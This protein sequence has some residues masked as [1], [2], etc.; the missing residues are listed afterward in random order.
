MYSA[1]R[2][3]LVVLLAFAGL[4]FGFG[5]GSG[6]EAATLRWKFKPG[7][8][9]RYTIDQKITTTAKL[10]GGQE[11]KN[12]L[13]QTVEMSWSVKS[14]NED[15]SAELTQTFDRVLD[16]VDGPFAKYE[17]D[18]KSGKEPEGPI[19]AARLPLFKAML[20]TPITFKMNA[21][22]EPSGFQVPEK[23]T[24]TLREAGPSA[25]AAGALFSEEGLKSMILQT[26]V[27]L[28]KDDL[29]PGKSWTRQTKESVPAIGT[30][31]LD[32][33]FTYDGP[34]D[35][36]GRKL[37]KIG[38]TTK[39]D[40]KPPADAKAEA[41]FPLKIKSQDSKGVIHFDN[42]AGHLVHLQLND[43]IERVATIMN[44]EINEVTETSTTRKLVKDEAK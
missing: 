39:V 16:K 23:L 15:G 27:V 44:M 2:R 22:G 6:A 8:T 35:A 5:F 21:Q 37:E 30:M 20:G 40:I 38:Q 17:Y 3:G 14:V 31:T 19:A 10:P 12:S 28:P 13:I 29:A 26:T 25:A 36:E 4:G 9:L 33:T 1:L 43:K 11:L 24:Q 32:T 7:E 18:S 41:A 34:D 42:D